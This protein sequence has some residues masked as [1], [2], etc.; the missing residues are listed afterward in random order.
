MKDWNKIFQSKIKNQKSKIFDICLFALLFIALSVLNVRAV[1]PGELMYQA[2][3]ADNVGNPLNGAYNIQFRIYDDPLAGGELYD[4]GATTVTVSNG[5]FNV[6]IGSAPA[7]TEIPRSLFQNTHP[8][9]LWLQVTV[10]GTDLAPRQKLVAA[11]YALAVPANSVG[12]AEIRDNA[13]GVNTPDL[14]DDAVAS[15]KIN[16][17]EITNTNISPSADISPNKINGGTFQAESYAFPDTAAFSN[18]FNLNNGTAGGANAIDLGTGSD[19]DVTAADVSVLTGGPASN[20][21]ALHTHTGLDTPPH[22]DYHAPAALGGGNPLEDY[23]LSLNGAPG[24][25]STVHEFN[26]AISTNPFTLGHNA[27]TQLIPHLHADLLDGQ[28]MDSFAL[29]SRL[30]NAG[31]GL[32]GGGDLTQD[33]VLSVNQSEVPLKWADET[34]AGG[35]TF[36]S[37]TNFPGTGVWDSNGNMGIGT[38]ADLG[39]YRLNVNGDLYTNSSLDIDAS[40]DTWPIPSTWTVNTSPDY[41][42]Y[43]IGNSVGIGFDTLPASLLQ[44]NGQI[45]STGY[46]FNSS[47]ANCRTSWP[48]TVFTDIPG[49]GLNGIYFSMGTGNVGIGDTAQEDIRLYVNGNAQVTGQMDGANLFGNGSNL[50]NLDADNID[51]GILSFAHGGTNAN[52]YLPNKIIMT[53]AGGTALTHHA[54]LS[55]TNVVAMNGSGQNSSIL[56][57]DNLTIPLSIAQGGTGS[58]DPYEGRNNLEMV[59]STTTVHAGPGLTNT[60]ADLSNDNVISVDTSA[61]MT[62]CNNSM[63]RKVWW[64][65]DHLECAKDQGSDAPITGDGSQDA[66]ELAV[67][68]SVSELTGVTDLTWEGAPANTLTLP[69]NLELLNGG[70]MSGDSI[71]NNSIRGSRI[72]NGEVLSAKVSFNYAGSSSKGGNAQNLSCTNCV[73]ETEVSF[74]YAG[75]SSK[76]GGASDLTCTTCVS[77]NEVSFGYALSSTKAGANASDLN[78]VDCVE[79]SDVDFSYA[80][81][82]SEGG[83]ALSMA[84]G[85]PGTCA[86][87]YARGI[88][89]SGDAAICTTDLR[90]DTVQASELSA[91]F[92]NNGILRRTASG[93]GS[94]PYS[95]YSSWNNAVSWGDHS[96]AG[97]A[98]VSH[99]HTGY[100]PLTG[101]S[102]TGNLIGTGF[103][104][105]NNAA[106]YVEMGNNSG[107]GYNFINSVGRALTINHFGAQDTF[108]NALGGSNVGIGTTSPQSKLH[109]RGSG[110]TTN[111]FLVQYGGTDIFRVTNS[112]IYFTEIFRV[113]G[114]ATVNGAVNAVVKAFVIDHPLE[115][116]KKELVHS[117]AEGPEISVFYRGEARLKNGKAVVT[118]PHYFEA[119]TRKENRSVILTCVDTYSRIYVSEEVENGRFEVSTIPEG[120]QDQSFFWEVKAV[121]ADIDPLV[122]E[123][124]K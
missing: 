121:R 42:Y 55:S 103:I 56:R 4:S 19:D 96:G 123:R 32:T 83:A 86:G 92:T 81:A 107:S 72:I 70:R 85:T 31:M 57:F 50:T 27:Q 94:I 101:G 58:S 114:H 67:W 20:A 90:N 104:A 52:A 43:D 97:Y 75:S 120:N 108:I 21:D 78:C 54:V 10:Q 118:L 71:E 15:A 12:S 37:I 51:A 124:D 33:R 109:V 77:G 65:S 79:S 113:E 110:G 66:G 25:V 3:L 5:V 59:A 14:A 34:I 82:S 53:N 8:N 60:Q 22:A 13:A 122:V 16:N 68:N 30:V 9:G 98:D 115:P 74:N 93:F 63:T 76:N 116:E 80:G 105:H 11:P 45:N 6:I 40:R 1:V 29:S 2:K 73:S 44:V 24:I 36:S 62:D 99:S 7:M 61:N 64:N 117:V 111:L 47:M 119:L 69:G 112:E 49:P 95:D 48:W 26:P 41:L 17:G 87:L 39:T 46:C 100:L 28:S 18:G 84:I 23:Y 38:T 102:L 35:W 91:L 88:D 89:S 106:R